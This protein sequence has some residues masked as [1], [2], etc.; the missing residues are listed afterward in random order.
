MPT[1]RQ[2]LTRILMTADAVGGV[3]QYSVDLISALEKHGVEVLLATLGPAPSQEQRNQLKQISNARLAEGDFALEWMESP[4][5]DVDRSKD[6]LLDL[7]QKFHP[8]V[9]HLN[10]YALANARCQSPIVSVAHSC[11]YSWWSAVHGC[12]PGAEWDEYHHRV[13][14]GLRRSAAVVAPSC[15]MSESVVLHYGLD[16]ARI[17]VISNFSLARVSTASEKEP[18]LLAAGRVWDKAKNIV[19]LD[20]IASQVIWPMHVAGKC[21]SIEDSSI[22]S[23]SM[24][25]L[26]ALSHEDLLQ[27]MERASIFVHPAL[28]EPFGLAVLEAAMSQCSLVLADIP[29]LRELW[30]GAAVFVDPHDPE[31]WSRELNR[32]VA[33][34]FE[35]E[36]LA[37][38]ALTRA[39]RYDAEASVTQYLDVYQSAIRYKHSGSGVAA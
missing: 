20:S 22:Y 21:G 28:Y 35:R 17:Y 16:R 9:I 7:E 38:Q 36:H 37:V 33:D 32:L 14:E 13:T 19:L 12:A 18:C 27:W 24:L 15:S 5:Q 2:P 11:V 25:R 29:S 4:W 39:K 23:G 34:S 31:A 26:G 3:W 10:G 30:Q 1:E 6:W 8:D